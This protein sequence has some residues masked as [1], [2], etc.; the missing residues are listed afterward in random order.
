MVTPE[1][2]KFLWKAYRPKYWFWEV[3]ETIRRLLITGVLSVIY[4]GTSLQIVVGIF[5]SICFVYAYDHYRPFPNK[6]HNLL[7][8]V[9]EYIILLYLIGALLMRTQAFAT[10]TGS[11]S[12][13]GSVSSVVDESSIGSFQVALMSVF[14]LLIV[15]FALLEIVPDYKLGA[16]HLHERGLLFSSLISGAAGKSVK[17]GN[18]HSGDKIEMAKLRDA[19]VKKDEECKNERERGKD[20]IRQNMEMTQYIQKIEA[21]V[22]GLRQRHKQQ[23]E[24]V[25][26]SDAS[27]SNPMFKSL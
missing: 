5:M 25:D 22:A 4:V 27:S 26:I 10:G 15:H 20:A 12:G 8:E 1:E 13:L 6:A 2:I 17:G 19:L 18:G 11:G 3:I 7:Q 21:E 14:I 16:I 23:Q 9:Q 24:E